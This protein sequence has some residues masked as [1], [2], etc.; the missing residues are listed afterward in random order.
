M[1][2][3]NNLTAVEFAVEKLEKLIP[4]GNQITIEIILEQAKEMSKKESKKI[5]MTAIKYVLLFLEHK[6][7]KSPK[8]SFEQYYNK[9][10][11]GEL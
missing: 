2:M 10:Y 4:S 3:E 11:G 7:S 6:T 5:W 8:E 1:F 9:T